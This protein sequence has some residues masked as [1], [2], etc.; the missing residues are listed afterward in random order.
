M[1]FSNTLNRLRE[2]TKGQRGRNGDVLVSAFDLRDLLTDYDRIDSKY[3]A[4][5]QSADH[6]PQRI[7]EQDAG[8]RALLEKLSAKAAEAKH[9]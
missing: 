3:R 1:S 7:T 8:G 5:H 6:E 2:A 9:V 4:L